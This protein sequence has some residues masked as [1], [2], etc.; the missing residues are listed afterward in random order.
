MPDRCTSHPLFMIADAA[1]AA[2]PLAGKDKLI[3]AD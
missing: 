3:S 1:E 2:P